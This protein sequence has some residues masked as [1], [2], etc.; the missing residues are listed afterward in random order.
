VE[1]ASTSLRN[2]YGTP[3]STS[4]YAQ[5]H[6]PVQRKANEP[7]FSPVCRVVVADRPT[8]SLLLMAAREGAGLSSLY[9]P[10]PL[11]L[12][13]ESAC[14]EVQNDIWVPNRLARR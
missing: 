4:S 9:Q 2:L 1:F 12:C 3:L 5:T 11:F 8:I 7:I 10:A 6:S 13:E 14:A